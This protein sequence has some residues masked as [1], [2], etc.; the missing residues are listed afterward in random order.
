MR[1]ST[2]QINDY[3]ARKAGDMP[4]RSRLSDRPLKR[5][6][7]HMRDDDSLPSDAAQ[8]ELRAAWQLGVIKG[9][10]PFEQGYVWSIDAARLIQLANGATSQAAEQLAVM[11]AITAEL[12]QCQNYSVQF[13]H[14]SDLAQYVDAFSTTYNAQL[15]RML[16]ASPADL[17]GVSSAAE[18]M[19]DVALTTLWQNAQKLVEQHGLRR[20]GRVRISEQKETPMKKNS[21]APTTTAPEQVAN[22]ES[23]SAHLTVWR[24][25]Q[26]TEAYRL[27]WLVEVSAGEPMRLICAFAQGNETQRAVIETAVTLLNIALAAHGP[28]EVVRLARGADGGFFGAETPLVDFASAFAETFLSKQQREKLV[29]IRANE[30]QTDLLR[31]IEAVQCARCQN[32]VEQ[33][34]EYA[35]CM[36]CGDAQ[37][38]R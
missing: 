16:G 27:E 1:T 17:G 24:F 32:P 12:L 9:V 35:I 8:A 21:I 31:T 15:A 37:F 3:F 20:D 34:G 26:A 28:E 7:V 10:V 19:S 22:F 13:E 2:I 29:A 6:L 18:Y 5:Y 33:F 30:E 23:T 14:D 25:V 11:L 38:V 36:N 4:A